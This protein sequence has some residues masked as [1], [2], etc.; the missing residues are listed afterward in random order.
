MEDHSLEEMTYLAASLE[1]DTLQRAG[2]DNIDGNEK[3]VKQWDVA[4]PQLGKVC[5][6]NVGGEECMRDI[7]TQR[8]H[9]LNQ[10]F[11]RPQEVESNESD[12]VI[13]PEVMRRSS[14]RRDDDLGPVS[15]RRQQSRCIVLLGAQPYHSDSG[16]R[17]R[18]SMMAFPVMPLAPVMKAT[19]PRGGAMAGV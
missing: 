18:F 7:V 3:I 16:L 10:L 17:I 2:S 19:F 14:S 1:T 4:L 5:G 12:A 6:M 11:N 15:P 8:S 9:L 13:L